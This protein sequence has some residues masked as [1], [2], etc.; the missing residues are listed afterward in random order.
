MENQISFI[1]SGKGPD[2]SSKSTVGINYTNNNY[3][4]PEIVGLCGSLEVTHF[5]VSENDQAVPAPKHDLSNNQILDFEIRSLSDE[6]EAY[7]ENS[8]SAAE[9]CDSF[10]VE[11]PESPGGEDVPGD[12]PAKA[13]I[14]CAPRT[15]DAESSKSKCTQRFARAFYVFLN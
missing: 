15:L 2:L 3:Q 13:I 9:V 5:A 11:E 8:D 4:D 10:L 7:L 14:D 1:N 6:D 12:Q